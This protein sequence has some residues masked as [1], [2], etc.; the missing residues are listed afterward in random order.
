VRYLA[1]LLT[2]LL[3]SGCSLFGRTTIVHDRMVVFTLPQPPKLQPDDGSVERWQ[4]NYSQV[5]EYAIRVTRGVH[6]Y[7]EYA[8]K[9]NL[10]FGY[11][12]EEEMAAIRKSYHMPPPKPKPETKE[13]ESPGH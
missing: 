9:H 3:L 4:A 12:K 13:N 7:N 8:L 5:A 1:L 10:E 6:V 2:V 11:F